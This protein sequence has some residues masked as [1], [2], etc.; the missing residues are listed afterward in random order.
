MCSAAQAVHQRC[1]PTECVVLVARPPPQP[2]GFRMSPGPCAARDV[3]RPTCARRASRHLCVRGPRRG[4]LVDVGGCARPA[5]APPN[6]PQVDVGRSAGGEAAMQMLG[7]PKI[8]STCR[9][10]AFPG[11]FGMPRLRL[12]DFRRARKKSY[13]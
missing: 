10:L 4:A 13:N 1:C 2:A 7:T 12:Q 9:T 8:C 3:H 6:S 11:L 5:A